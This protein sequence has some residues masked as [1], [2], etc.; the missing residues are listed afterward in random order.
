MAVVRFQI[1]GLS[2]WVAGLWRRWMMEH[3]MPEAVNLVGPPYPGQRAKSPYSSV[4]KEQKLQYTTLGPQ[5]G[6]TG[7]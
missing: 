3:V 2:V 1:V 7:E 6:Q 4:G 5:M